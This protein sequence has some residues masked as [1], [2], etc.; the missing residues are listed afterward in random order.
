MRRDEYGL[1]QRTMLFGNF[2][3]MDAVMAAAFV[4]FVVWLWF[5]VPTMR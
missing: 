5:G 3:L 4:L 2:C 1:P